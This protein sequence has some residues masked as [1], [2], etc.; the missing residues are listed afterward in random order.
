MK[1]L[2][3]LVIF[4]G[5]YL[6]HYLA[7]VQSDKCLVLRMERGIISK[8]KSCFPREVPPKKKEL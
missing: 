8:V 4:S 5:K 2:I 7:A 3:V 1:K 6:I